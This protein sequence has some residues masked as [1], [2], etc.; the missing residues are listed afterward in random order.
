MMAK[1]KFDRLGRLEM[2]DLDTHPLF[3][4]FNPIQGGLGHPSFLVLFDF[5]SNPHPIQVRASLE[6]R[7]WGL[8][9]RM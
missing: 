1:P 6:K 7:Y 9:N 4:I 2:A 3:S 8:R 5:Q